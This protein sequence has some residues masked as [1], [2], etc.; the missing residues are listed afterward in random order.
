MSTAVILPGP[1]PAIP[2][3]SFTALAEVAILAGQPL[4]FSADTVGSVVLC[5]S[6]SGVGRIHVCCG[7]AVNNAQPGQ[8]V[9][10]QYAGILSLT[11]AQWALVV[12][13]GGLVTSD[14]YY[15][16]DGVTSGI[17]TATP[18]SGLSTVTPVCIAKSGTDVLMQVAIP[19]TT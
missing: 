7:L 1:G 19:V 15:V 12:D 3:G 16:A 6:R 18:P 2:E 10:V 11:L 9:L 5:S 17:L 14:A 8:P 4:A 13:T